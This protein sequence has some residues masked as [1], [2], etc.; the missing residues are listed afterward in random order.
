V[1]EEEDEEGA[2]LL[3]CFVKSLIRIFCGY[4]GGRKKLGDL[5][6]L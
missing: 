6:A 5:V 3:G 1:K 2:W 4:Y